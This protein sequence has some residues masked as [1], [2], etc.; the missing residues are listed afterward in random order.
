[1]I[2]SR[3]EVGSLP[4]RFLFPQLRR[5]EVDDAIIGISYQRAPNSRQLQQYCLPS[6]RELVTRMYPLY[7]WNTARVMSFKGTSASSPRRRDASLVDI[8]TQPPSYMLAA[9]KRHPGDLNFCVIQLRTPHGLPWM[10]AM[11]KRLS[12]TPSPCCTRGPPMIACPDPSEVRR[13]R[14]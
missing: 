14:S 6:Y 11:V 5:Q 2:E 10:Y 4:S 8:P 13:R 9:T 12:H 3:R 7:E 1:M